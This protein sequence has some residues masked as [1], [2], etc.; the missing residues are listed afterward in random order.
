MRGYWWGF[1]VRVPKSG[2]TTRVRGRTWEQTEQNMRYRNLGQR[3]PEDPR[4]Q[5]TGRTMTTRVTSPRRCSRGVGCWRWKLAGHTHVRHS[6]TSEPYPRSARVFR[7]WCISVENNKAW[8]RWTTPVPRAINMLTLAMRREH[9]DTKGDGHAQQQ[10][11]R[12]GS[13]SATGGDSS[14]TATDEFVDILQVQQLLLDT[15]S[16]STTTTSAGNGGRG[17]RGRGREPPPPR[18]LDA[19]SAFAAPSYYY[20]SYGTHLTPPA[21]SVDDLVA[22]WFAGPSTSAGAFFYPLSS[23]V[24]CVY[25]SVQCSLMS[26]AICP[27][28]PHITFLFVV[29]LGCIPYDAHPILPT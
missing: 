4:T 15:S 13:A 18:L 26:R 7:W 25:V 29:T 27:R 17:G 5:N 11:P 12:E 8:Q 9:D 21:T 1:A 22:L 28:L 6:F 10:R 23:D 19:S 14:V 20:G 3:N 2:E 16:A 24:V